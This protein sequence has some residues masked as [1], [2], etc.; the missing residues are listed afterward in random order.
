MTSIGETLRRERLKR[1]LELGQ[2]AQELKISARFLEAIE[3]GEL[4]KLPGGVFTRSFIIQYARLPG[5]DA[6]E[7]AGQLQRTLDPPP[8]V[9]ASVEEPKPADS[10][11]RRWKF[12]WYVWTEYR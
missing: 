9:P 4:D 12:M 7:I 2:I 8:E 6:E 5:L 10:A 11:I 1:N 3:A